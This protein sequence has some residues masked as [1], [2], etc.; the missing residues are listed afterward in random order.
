[1]VLVVCSESKLLMSGSGVRLSDDP[2]KVSDLHSRGP[3]L[4]AD[5]VELA[6][7]C[8]SNRVGGSI[9]IQ[10]LGPNL[11]FCQRPSNLDPPL[12]GVAQVKL[13]RLS[14]SEQEERDRDL[15][16]RRPCAGPFPP[17]QPDRR[18]RG[19]CG[20]RRRDVLARAPHL[21]LNLSRIQAIPRFAIANAI[22]VKRRPR[23]NRIG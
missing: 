23:V 12:R 20:R 13:T 7:R 22:V 6:I 5:R 4:I 10:R 3:T 17:D 1:M 19:L 18:N 9:D 11:D 16:L 8:A 21:R 2:P 14:P 15:P